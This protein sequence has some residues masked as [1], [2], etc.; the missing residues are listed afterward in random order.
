[1]QRQLTT[2]HATPT[3]VMT[4]NPTLIKHLKYSDKPCNP[5]QHT[6]KQSDAKP[7]NTNA[8]KQATTSN[9]KP[10]HH[11]AKPG[12]KYTS[13]STISH[14]VPCHVSLIHVTSQACQD[15]MSQ[16]KVSNPKQR[17][18]TSHKGTLHQVT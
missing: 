17:C 13:L 10:K 16:A 18:A 8:A 15:N 14:P 3:V 12:H 5:L 11:Q 7:T 9:P 4:N 6:L 1:M 2:N